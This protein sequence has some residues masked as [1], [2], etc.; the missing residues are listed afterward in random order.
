MG[1]SDLA[2]MPCA[3]ARAIERVGDT[4]T[5]MILRELFLGSRRFDDLQQNTGASPHILSQRLK[6][7]VSE[8]ILV[9]R[10][11]ND[12]PVRYEYRLTQK[13]R[14]L[15]PVIIALKRWGQTWQAGPD[16]V[17]LIHKACGHEMMPELTCPECKRPVSAV[18]VEATIGPGFRAPRGKTSRE[19][20]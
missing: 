10:S 14:D 19:H 4:W 8:G 18:D 3:V 11:Y 1:R 20:R 12:R 2:D 15:W 7:M 9:K 5:L 16:P 6:S 17:T 13:G